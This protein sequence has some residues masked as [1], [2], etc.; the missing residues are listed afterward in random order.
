MQWEER[1][2]FGTYLSVPKGKG[3]W[4]QIPTVNGFVV[5]EV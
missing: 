1:N 4:L 3:S 5:L 2:V